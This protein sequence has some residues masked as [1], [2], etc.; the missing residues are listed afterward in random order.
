MKH[1]IITRS[2]ILA[3]VLQFGLGVFMTYKAAADP[4]MCLS[5]R[6]HLASTLMWT[7][8]HFTAFPVAY[9]GFPDGHLC[10]FVE[11]RIEELVYTVFALLFG[12]RRCSSLDPYTRFTSLASILDVGA[13]AVIVMRLV[14]RRPSS[15]RMSSLVQAIVKDA[16]LYVLLL[17][18]S[19]IIF[20]SIL[21]SARVCTTLISRN[22]V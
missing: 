15:V 20:M 3:I 13:L 5:F 18:A 11:Q 2:F 8:F 22:N 14:W 6:V 17:C 7:R 19:R 21:V 9:P 16:T 4:G 12:K 10:I 1:K